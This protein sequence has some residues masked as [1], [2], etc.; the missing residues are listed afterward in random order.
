VFYGVPDGKNEEYLEFSVIY[1][2][3][4]VRNPAEKVRNPARK[5]RNSA[6]KVRNS[7]R[8]WWVIHSLK[9]PPL[10]KFHP[11]DSIVLFKCLYLKGEKFGGIRHAT[12]HRSRNR[13]KT[14][15]KVRNPAI[16]GL[17][18]GE[19]SCLIFSP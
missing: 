14:S 17:P 18:L 15:L 3:G 10:K 7:A 13:G 11:I 6:R 5:V 12:E 2:K 16:S 8:F 4:K 19:K 1:E 9:N